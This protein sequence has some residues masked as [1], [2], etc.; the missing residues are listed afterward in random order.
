M[1][2]NERDKVNILTN[3]SSNYTELSQFDDARKV[4]DKALSIDSTDTHS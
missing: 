4:L 2:M 3:L 1:T